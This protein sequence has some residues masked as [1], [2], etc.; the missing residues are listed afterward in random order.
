MTTTPMLMRNIDEGGAAVHKIWLDVYHPK[1][2]DAEG[3]KISQ[4]KVE[5]SFELLPLEVADKNVNGKGR[6]N[7][8]NFPVLDPPKG[9]FSFSLNPF[10]ML[11]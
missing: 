3:K 9:R 1:E 4:G 8:N 10:V 5:V 7:P 6:D 11:K 2:K